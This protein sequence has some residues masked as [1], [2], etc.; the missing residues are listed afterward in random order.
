MFHDTISIWVCKSTSADCLFCVEIFGWL[1]SFSLP[2]KGFHF[3]S[4][5]FPLPSSVIAVYPVHLRLAY[6]YRSKNMNWESESD[7]PISYFCF[8]DYTF[9]E[10]CSDQTHSS[11]AAH[12]EW[13]NDSRDSWEETFVFLLGLSKC[14]VHRRC[15]F[16]YLSNLIAI[17]MQCVIFID[18]LE[19]QI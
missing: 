3:F 10:R 19:S 18:D 9:L 17:P 6:S 11:R 15:F 4:F 2:S 14:V 7:F 16:K 8:V 5:S 13:N 12:S 1:W